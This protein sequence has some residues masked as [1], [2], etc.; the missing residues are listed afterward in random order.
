M[1]RTKEIKSDIKGVLSFD[2]CEK[3]IRYKC[4]LYCYKAHFEF[5]YF[6]TTPRDR[7]KFKEEFSF[8]VKDL[9]RI[10]FEKEFASYHFHLWLKRLG[11]NFSRLE[12]E[13]FLSEQMG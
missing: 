5:F 12:I 8:F 2:E 9:N 10:N 3:S 7:L 13:E 1:K 6:R 11:L 4:M